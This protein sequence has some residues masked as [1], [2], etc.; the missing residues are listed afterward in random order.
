[1]V[2]STQKLIMVYERFG[3]L[4]YVLYLTADI[5]GGVLL[6]F[7]YILSRLGLL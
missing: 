4:N 7:V 5:Y 1:M 3:L 2:P 6:F